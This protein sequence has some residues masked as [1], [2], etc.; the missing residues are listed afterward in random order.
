MGGGGGGGGGVVCVQWLI[1]RGNGTSLSDS[2]TSLVF[3]KVLLWNKIAHNPTFVCNLA[4]VLSHSS[5]GL[6]GTTRGCS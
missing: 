1:Q 5:L 6:G 2:L 3:N 4:P